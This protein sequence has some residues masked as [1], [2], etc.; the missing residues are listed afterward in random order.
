MLKSLK[1]CEDHQVL[2]PEL[3][4]ASPLHPQ[5]MLSHPTKD[6]YNENLLLIV[7]NNNDKNILNRYSFLTIKIINHFN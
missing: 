2:V 3:L 4:E 6:Y 5:K 1:Q 7:S